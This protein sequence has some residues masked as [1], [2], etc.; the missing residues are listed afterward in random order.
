MQPYD[1]VKNSHLLKERGIGFEEIIKEIEKGN[2]VVIL[3]HHN[4]EKYPNQRI[5][6]KEI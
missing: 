5:M 2:I 4:P 1:D 3:E 6:Q